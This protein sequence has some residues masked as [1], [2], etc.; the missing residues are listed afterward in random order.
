MS[1]L[2]GAD[3]LADYWIPS[4]TAG[5]AIAAGD[6][7]ALDLSDNKIYKA[8]ASAWAYR[9]NLIG[10]AISGGA[11]GASIPVNDTSIV[12][13][14]TGLTAGSMYYL[15]DT[16]GA[17]ATS[18][19]TIER[20]IGRAISA[21]RIKRPKN[22]AAASGLISRSLSSATA[23]APVSAYISGIGQT[24]P[25]FQ[26]ILNGTTL[27]SH[28]TGNPINDTTLILEPDDVVTMSASGLGT[29][30]SVTTP[31]VRILDR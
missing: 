6:A 10:F 27:K 28:G 1:I 3:V 20:R 16:Q 14:K 18:A 5:E 26:V 2:D 15:S 12:A 30:T 22:G 31:V 25:Q 29:G 4:Y 23:Y 17:I 19:G 9:I 24:S 11:S 13:E 21:T 7:V 8:S